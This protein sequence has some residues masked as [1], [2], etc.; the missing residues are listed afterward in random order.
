M[1]YGFLEKSTGYQVKTPKLKRYWLQMNLPIATPKYPAAFG[2]LLSMIS[3]RSYV[4]SE[5]HA[6]TFTNL[7]STFKGYNKQI[8]VQITLTNNTKHFSVRRF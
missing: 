5:P 2:P 3:V 8:K 7:A 4:I 6:N 1:Y